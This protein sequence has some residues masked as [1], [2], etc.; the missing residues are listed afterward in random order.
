MK[1]LLRDA[2]FAPAKKMFATGEIRFSVEKTIYGLA[3][4]TRDIS[5]DLCFSCLNYALQD[6]MACCSFLKDG[7]L[8][9]RNCNMKFALFRFF[10]TSDYLLTYST[11]KGGKWK[12]WM[13][14][15]VSCGSILVLAVLV[16]KES[17]NAL[18]KELASP[19]GVAI[20]QGD[21][22]TSE[23]MLFIDL[24]TIQTATND[25]SDINKLG[26]GGF[27]SVYKG[28]LPDGK[29]VAVKEIMA[30]LRGIYK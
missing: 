7:I 25:F 30:R 26:Q 28:V 21:L 1:N 12:T 18:L 19:K 4:C 20:T 14:L 23:G 27:G 15:L 13:V 2:A 24:A 11:T 17:Q 8:P 5:K 16:D 6:L 10:N 29:E 22:V 3:Q 9:S